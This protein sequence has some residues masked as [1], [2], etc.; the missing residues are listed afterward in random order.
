MTIKYTVIKVEPKGTSQHCWECL[1]RVSKSLSERWHSCS[2]C[3]QELDRD[4][5]SP[6]PLAPLP[7]G[8]GGGLD[9]CQHRGRTSPHTKQRSGFLWL[10]NPALS[11]I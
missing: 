9:C 5:N 7:G 3:G 10:K 1:N 4:Y 2:Y 6:T 11:R 8:D